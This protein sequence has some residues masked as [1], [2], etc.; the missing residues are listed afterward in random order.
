MI[1]SIVS[2]DEYECQQCEKKKIKLLNKIE[3]RNEVK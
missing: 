2:Y 1:D 3:C